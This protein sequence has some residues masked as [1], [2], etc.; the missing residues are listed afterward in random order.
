DA[1]LPSLFLVAQATVEQLVVAVE[2]GFEV[3]QAE[4]L[5]RGSDVQVTEIADLHLHPRAHLLGRHVERPVE[6]LLEL[7]AQ[8]PDLTVDLV[9]SLG[10]GRRAAARRLRRIAPRAALRRDLP[11]RAPDIRLRA[12]EV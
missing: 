12:S 8:R 6:E 4:G 10:D 9:Q 7:D 11:L 3:A 2:P 1:G 5:D